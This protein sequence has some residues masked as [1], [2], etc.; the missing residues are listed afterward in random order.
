MQ[1]QCNYKLTIAYDGTNYC[2]WQIQPNGLSIQASLEAALKTIL[3]EP[4]QLIGSGRTD[5]GVHA[6]G[7]VAHFKFHES[8]H[9]YRLRASLNGLVPRDIRV[10]GI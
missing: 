6:H 5:S 1:P 4:V 2:G 3:R 9:L 8:L 10:L 7:Q